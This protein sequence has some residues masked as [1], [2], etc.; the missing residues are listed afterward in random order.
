MKNYFTEILE[1]LDDGNA[2][3]KMAQNG[4][5][6]AMIDFHSKHL[7]N[8][9][10]IINTRNSTGKTGLMLAIENEHPKLAEWLI[11][12]GAEVDLQDEFGINAS[13]SAIIKGYN[14]LVEKITE[15][16]GAFYIVEDIYDAMKMN[17]GTVANQLFRRIFCNS[18]FF[19]THV[20]LGTLTFQKILNHKNFLEK[21]DLRQRHKDEVAD[22]I[23]AKVIEKRTDI[24]PNIAINLFS[25]ELIYS[26]LSEEKNNQL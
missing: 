15:R 8:F 17:K 7:E 3:V 16:A 9:E 24:W 23:I 10:E 4:D 2:F 22:L 25:N 14:K 12:K 11:D 26:Q 13:T 1:M 19:G 18:K 6:Q 21:L 5:L 20:H